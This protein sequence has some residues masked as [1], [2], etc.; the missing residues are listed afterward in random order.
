MARKVT[1]AAVGDGTDPRTLRKIGAEDANAGVISTGD[2]LAASALTALVMR[3][4]GLDDIYVKVVSHDHA[5]LIEKIGVTETIFPERESGIR[6]GKRISGL[7][8]LNYVQLGPGFVAQEMEVPPAWIGKSL[9]E[10]ELPRT[11]GISVIAV[12]DILRD[13]IQPVPAPDEL[14]KDSD[15][16]LVAGTEANLAKIAGPR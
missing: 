2:D 8:L 11:Y 9:R 1:R 15:T 14:L 6:L 4:L 10:L 16:L 12:H 3:D 7:F 13:R 5:R